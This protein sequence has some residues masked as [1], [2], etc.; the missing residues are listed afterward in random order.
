MLE[1]AGSAPLAQAG[2]EPSTQ[3]KEP[4]LPCTG[5]AFSSQLASGCVAAAGGRA[6][7]CFPAFSLFLAAE[8][9][10]WCF[11]AFDRACVRCP[12]WAHARDPRCD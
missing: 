1:G 4:S 9:L 5:V 12:C 11:S 2:S 6:A 10:T 3:E 7:K 8:C